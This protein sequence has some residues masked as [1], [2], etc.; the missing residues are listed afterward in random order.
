VDSLVKDIIS[1]IVALASGKALEENF[2]VL[3][4]DANF[5]NPDVRDL[6]SL[7]HD[8]QTRSVSGRPKK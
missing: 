3:R 4:K 5:A 2:V 7:P 6:H 8:I 1:P